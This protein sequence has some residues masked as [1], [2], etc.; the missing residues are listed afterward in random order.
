MVEGISGKVGGWGRL[1]LLLAA[2]A[3]VGTAQALRR[4][5]PWLSFAGFGVG[6]LMFLTIALSLSDPLRA[7]I[8]TIL[9]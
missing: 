6:M 4:T 2:V 1:A 8:S 7:W 5:H 3:I 9:P